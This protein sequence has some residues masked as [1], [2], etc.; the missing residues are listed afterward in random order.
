[1]KK[2]TYLCLLSLL[3]ILSLA[4]IKNPSFDKYKKE[5]DECWGKKPQDLD[6][7]IEKY[8]LAKIIDNSCI[9]CGDRINQAIANQNKIAEEKA[10][11][12]RLTKNAKEKSD[13][14]EAE[15]IAKI[16][17]EKSDK[18][19][20]E[21]LIKIKKRQADIQENISIADIALEKAKK[22]EEDERI[23]R[24]AL[25]K[26]DKEESDKKVALEKEK[27]YRIE[28]EKLVIEK[29]EKVEA[30][31]KE[32]ANQLAKI[33]QEKKKKESEKYAQN[34]IVEKQK[35]LYQDKTKRWKTKLI[36]TAG[37][38]VGAGVYALVL[39]SQ[40]QNKLNTLSSAATLADPT[41]IGTINNQVNYDVYK[42]AY[43]DG[44]NFQNQ[45]TLRNVCVGIA[46]GAAVLETYLVFN[47]PKPKTQAFS[48]RP[49]QDTWGVA[50]NY[51]F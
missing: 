4:Q 44:K 36:V 47:K 19:E 15:R 20:A 43:D 22:K 9:I 24:I 11:S 40:W 21:R 33:E 26:A 45:Q 31:K 1:M 14:A 41:N 25:E 37:I 48:I 32:K 42:T 8:R 50:L 13:K 27:A 49:A 16:A 46:L 18:A 38:S 12:E 30:E 5:A 35:M 28:V 7:V 6:C 29:A 17:K 34:K 10:E 51:H 23:A 3:P 2:L 39:N